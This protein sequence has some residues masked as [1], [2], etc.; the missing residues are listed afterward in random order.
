MP[1]PIQVP[2]VP[3]PIQ[4]PKVPTPIQVPIVPTPIQVSS[5]YPYSRF[6]DEI[7]NEF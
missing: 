4:L 2:I 7:S 3:T 1:T 5:P 6:V